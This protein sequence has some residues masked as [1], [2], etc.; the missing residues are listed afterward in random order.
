MHYGKVAGP[1]PVM[2]RSGLTP[3]GHWLPDNKLSQRPRCDSCLE[4]IN[5]GFTREFIVF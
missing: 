5:A 3:K 1:P 2:P 4:S